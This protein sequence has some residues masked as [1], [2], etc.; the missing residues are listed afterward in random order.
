M[1][2]EPTGYLD[3]TNESLVMDILNG[4]HRQGGTIIVV[5]HSPEVAQHAERV[6]VLEH[7]RVASDSRGADFSDPSEASQ[8]A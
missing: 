5:T 1:A 7:G 3:G 2:D 4:L 8:T 6:V